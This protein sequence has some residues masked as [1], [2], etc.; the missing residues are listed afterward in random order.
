MNYITIFSP[1]PNLS[2]RTVSPGSLAFSSVWLVA[3]LL[4]LV[5][6]WLLHRWVEA[7]AERGR[8]LL[9]GRPAALT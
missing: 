2:Q 4:S 9:W 7:P 8:K 6:D 3:V 5:S 1:L